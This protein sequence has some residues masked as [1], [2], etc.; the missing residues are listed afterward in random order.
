MLPSIFLFV[1]SLTVPPPCRFAGMSK[2]QR[3]KARQKAS[4]GK[5]A[6]QQKQQEDSSDES[7]VSSKKLQAQLAED[8]RTISL[9]RTAAARARSNVGAKIS[10]PTPALAPI[11]SV[12][13][14]RF[15]EPLTTQTH[16]LSIEQTTWSASAPSKHVLR[17]TNGTNVFG[18]RIPSRTPTPATQSTVPLVPYTRLGQQHSIDIT[19]QYLPQRTNYTPVAPAGFPYVFRADS[20]AT[21]LH[22]LEASFKTQDTTVGAP[23]TTRRPTTCT[24]ILNVHPNVTP[25]LSHSSLGLVPSSVQPVVQTGRISPKKIIASQT[26]EDGHFEFLKKLMHSFPQEKK[27]LVSPMRLSSDKM[28]SD[29]IHVFVSNI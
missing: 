19:S 14:S 22:H 17:C 27:C 9:S 21:A 4:K 15:V 24:D 6:V 13:A 23:Y 8:L 12:L 26:K 1:N 5:Q 10:P 11:A 3:K 18:G 2:K 25:F 28:T 20:N 7:G 16:P 29:G